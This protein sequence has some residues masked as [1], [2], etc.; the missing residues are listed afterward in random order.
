MIGQMKSLLRH[1]EEYVETN[2]ELAKLKAV[3]K[4]SETVSYFVSLI[5]IT[6]VAI[7]TTMMLLIGFSILIGRAM[8]RTEF[9]FFIVAGGMAVFCIILYAYRKP[10]LKNTFCDLMIKKILG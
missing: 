5:V 3:S 7:L 6:G 1:T 10:L 8:G 9:G 2:I 4:T